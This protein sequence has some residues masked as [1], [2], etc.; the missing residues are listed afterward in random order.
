MWS[1]THMSELA[2]ITP[3]FR[4]DADIFADL[5]RSVLE[6][7]PPDTVHHVFV[8]EGDRSRFAGHE[9]PRCRI[10]T[11]R[12]ILPRRYLRIGQRDSYVNARR[13]WPPVRGW[14]TQQAIKIAAAAQLDA[15]VVL[16][17]DSDIVLVRPVT[18]ARFRID[19]RRSLHRVANGV[20]ADLE[21]HVVWHRVARLLF[22]LPPQSP[23]LPDYVS[24]FN[25][26][27]PAAVR[28]MQRRISD[29]T[30]R[31]W[32]DAFTAQLHVSEFILYGVFVDEVLGGSGPRLPE[33]TTSCHN[34]WQRTPLD[35][36]G[37][38]DFADRLG[39]DAVAMMISAKS[40]TPY[41]VRQ[42]AIRRCAEIVRAGGTGG[43]AQ[44]LAAQ[45]AVSES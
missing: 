42:V 2:V 26:W 44:S 34:T 33:D 3:S 41:E 17:A 38:V 22:G 36:D 28:A 37:A 35:H 7:T 45:P 18:A 11:S 29:T 43:P 20:T 9:G 25:F 14:V 19:G 5:H 24:S 15:D 30:G 31:H 10:W 40:R 32:L 6:F 21:R 23:P 27:E 39:P 1:A 8:P 16:V 13:P 12:E 4:G